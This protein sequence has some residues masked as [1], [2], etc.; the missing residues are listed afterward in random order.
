MNITSCDPKSVSALRKSALYLQNVKNLELTKMNFAGIF[1][2]LGLYL[3]RS[4]FC[5]T[6][7]V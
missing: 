6:R 3:E 7:E 2:T 5:F 4:Y 1:R